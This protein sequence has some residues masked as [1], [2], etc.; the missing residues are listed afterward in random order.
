MGKWK[1][2]TLSDP[3]SLLEVRLAPETGERGLCPP[4]QVPVRCT[5]KYDEGRVVAEPNV[6]LCRQLV[7]GYGLGY[8][9]ATGQPEV[10]STNCI[11]SGY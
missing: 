7:P 10:R 2:A 5:A 1:G 11:T 9:L 8:S 6:R 4:T 3:L